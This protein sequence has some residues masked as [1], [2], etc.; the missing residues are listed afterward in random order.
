MASPK[1]EREALCRYLPSRRSTNSE[2]DTALDAVSSSIQ[3]QDRALEES[4]TG[5]EWPASADG[6]HMGSLFRNIRIRHHE[7]LI[8]GDERL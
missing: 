6:V 1:C 5:E 8:H 4:A 7:P 2:P 3:D